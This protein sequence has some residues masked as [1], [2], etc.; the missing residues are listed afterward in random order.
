MVASGARCAGSVGPPS[1]WDPVR[2][3]AHGDV[4]VVKRKDHAVASGDRAETKASTSRAV[5]AVNDVRVLIYPHDLAIGGSQ[6]N[7]IE[8]ASALAE[9]GHEMVIFGRPG[10]LVERVRDFGMEF[11]ETPIPAAQTLA[12]CSGC[13]GQTS[14]RSLDR[15]DSRVRV[16]ADT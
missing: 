12:D 2:S 4:A 8:L 3:V 10:P 15:R 1:R 6:L 11:V 9:R 7:A 13:A 16:A 5:K 14:R